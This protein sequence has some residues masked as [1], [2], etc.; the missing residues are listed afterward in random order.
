MNEP[1]TFPE[2]ISL[3]EDAKDFVLGLLNRDV[4]QRLGFKE[5][6]FKRLQEHGWFKDYNWDAVESKQLEPPFKPDV[7]RRNKGLL[8]WMNS[9]LTS[10]IRISVPTLIQH[11]SLRRSC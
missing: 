9:W 2:D 8:S 1:V 4:N 10:Y 11:T 7:S 5:Q 3:S 6:G